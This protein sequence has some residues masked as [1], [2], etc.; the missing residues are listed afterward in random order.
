VPSLKETRE[1]NLLA[2]LHRFRSEPR[3]AIENTFKIKAYGQR[4]LVPLLFNEAQMRLYAAHQYFRE[5]RMPVRIIVVKAR[6][7][8]LSTGVESLLFHDTITNP[9]TNS[10]IV[11]HLLKPSENVLN[12][13]TRFWKNLPEH[14]IHTSGGKPHKFEVRPKLLAKYNNTPSADKMEF[15]EPLLS[16]VYICSAKSYDAYLSFDFQNIHFSEAS[17]FDDAEEAFRS[18]MP[19]LGES[20]HTAVY[21]ESTAAGQSG[22]G[23][24]FYE[25]ALDASLSTHTRYGQ[26]KLVFVP[27]HEMVN[28]FRIPFADDGARREFERNLKS[29]ERDVIKQFPHVTLE[30]MH[31]YVSKHNEPPYNKRPELFLQEYPGTLVE[32]FLSS[33]ESVFSI[34]ALTRLSCRTTE[35]RWRGDVYWGDSDSQNRYIAT[36]DAVRR[37]KFRSIEEARA[38][39]FAPH[40][41]EKTAS[42]LQVWR[43]PNSGERLVIG[44]DVGAGNPLSPDGDYSTACVLATSDFGRDELI[45]TWRGKLNT[46][47]FGEVLAALAWGCKNMVGSSG[48]VI[49]APEWTGPGTATCTSIDHNQ[50]YSL[51]HYRIPG[52]SG[53]PTSKHIGWESNL[54]TVPFAVNTMVRAVETDTVNIYSE[55]LVME[56]SS[57]RQLSRID[58]QYG[59]VNRHDD[60]VSSFYIAC[61]V[62]KL[63]GALLGAEWEPRTIDL[64]VPVPSDGSREPFDPFE[65]QEPSPYDYGEEEE[66]ADD[67][68][69]VL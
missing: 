56:M 27:W 46:I 22:K 37:P 5:R 9:L 49:L 68:F 64:D 33:G 59:G 44:A 63:E 31:W 45:M 3:F 67:L 66:D 61:A 26:M 50:L 17:R 8:G 25:Q 7:V 58:E 6:R 15:D 38:D 42:C 51:W 18:L 40:D 21:I 36:N 12:M 30:Q 53:T 23:E 16:N 52:T 43:W 48:Y 14:V 65:P 1:D 13:C 60:L 19:T 2:K 10:L 55:E 29:E 24:W 32:A 62:A 57:F 35:P 11:T 39:G 20:A 47:A 69:Y 41:A 54:K 28:S 4:A 34:P